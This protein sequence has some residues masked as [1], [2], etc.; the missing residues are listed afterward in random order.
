MS[1]GVSAAVHWLTGTTHL[2]VAEVLELVDEVT[3]HGGFEVVDRMRWLYRTQYVSVEGL[4]VLVDPMQGNMPPV[5]VDVP[6]RACEY[7]GAS[8]VRELA[9][10]LQPTRV[11]FAWDGVGFTVA[12]ARSW[13]VRRDVRTRA[14]SAVGT[15]QLWETP[16]E[17][18]SVTVG[19]KASTWQFQVYD[20]RGPVRGELRLRGERATAAY[21]VLMGDPSGWSA[22]FL[23]ILR[24]LVDFVDRSQA[25]RAEDCPLLPSWAGFVAGAQRVVVRLAGKAAPSFERA[26]EWVLR[27]VAPTLVTLVRGGL[28]LRDVLQEGAR[29]STTRH[30]ALAAVWRGGGLSPLGSV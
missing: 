15:D 17:G 16:K 10:I 5:C 25:A 13:L 11:D 21:D 23:G 7:L 3:G 18:D 9:S 1:G 12:N 6:G 8:R 28:E 19:S 4:R 20:R 22:G 29:R 26:R 27:Q 24:G 30:V 14:R 2:D